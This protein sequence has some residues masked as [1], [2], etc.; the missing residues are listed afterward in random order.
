M[1]DSEGIA[2]YV[3]G[4]LEKTIFSTLGKVEPYK[5]CSIIDMVMLCE[6]VLRSNK[7]IFHLP[8][9]IIF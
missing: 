6:T 3:S 5:R 4:K 2:Q 1:Y 8:S 9:V 7:L